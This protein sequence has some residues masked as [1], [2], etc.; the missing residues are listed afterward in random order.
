MSPAE[1]ARQAQADLTA[2]VRRVHVIHRDLMRDLA[3]SE[4]R[5]DV[6]AQH[7][8]QARFSE[9]WIREIDGEAA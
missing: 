5:A 2:N 1:Q 7:A 8:A 4:T 6:A 9:G 3:A